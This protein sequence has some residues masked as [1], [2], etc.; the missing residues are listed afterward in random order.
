MI[1]RTD[2]TTSKSDQVA[3]CLTSEDGLLKLKRW[4]VAR[5]W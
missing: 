1:Q 4:F 5:Q 3:A 2:S